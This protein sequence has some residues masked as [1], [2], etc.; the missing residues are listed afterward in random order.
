MILFTTALS[1]PMAYCRFKSRSILGPS[2][3]HGMLNPLGMLTV[4][5]V[6]G[7]NPLVGFVAG[8]AGIAVTALLAAGIFFFDKNFVRDYRTL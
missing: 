7:A 8:I 1:F 6:V 5:F 3:F 2:A 4:F